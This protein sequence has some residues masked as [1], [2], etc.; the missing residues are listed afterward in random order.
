[1]PDRTLLTRTSLVALVLTILHVT[2]DIVRGISPAGPDNLGGVLI[3]VVWAVGT[4]MLS[5]HRTGVVIM[6]LGGVFAAA[7]PVLHM[8]GARY[9]ALAAS[10][11]G[12]FFVSTLFAVGT[13]G[14]LAVLEAGRV[15]WVWRDGRP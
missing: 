13:A 11:G 8:R 3:F 6:L 2:D 1:M 4:L 10:E 15:M 12:F 7:M 14:V 5:K 9:P